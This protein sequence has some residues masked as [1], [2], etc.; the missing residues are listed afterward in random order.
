MKRLEH[1]LFLWGRTR[2]CPGHSLKEARTTAASQNLRHCLAKACGRKTNP[3]KRGQDTLPETPASSRANE[4]LLASGP[5]ASG[6]PVE[7]DRSRVPTPRPCLLLGLLLW[8]SRLGHTHGGRHKQGAHPEALPASRLLRQTHTARGPVTSGYKATM[9]L[10]ELQPAAAASKRVGI[11]I[12][13]AYH[14]VE[15]MPGLGCQRPG[16][17]FLTS[18]SLISLP[19][20]EGM[21]LSLKGGEVGE[22]MV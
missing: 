5:A 20:H 3:E 9:R 8:A 2:V 14:L 6:T 21:G 1:P 13:S 11:P 16:V 10:P 7:G 18:P 12:P 22:Q 19:L 17:R 15:V 4:A